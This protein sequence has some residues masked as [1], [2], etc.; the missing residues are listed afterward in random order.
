MRASNSRVLARAVPA[1]AILAAGFVYGFFTHKYQLPPYHL[2]RSLFVEPEPI[3][4]T[5]PHTGGRWE[6]TPAWI[7][8]LE[9]HA[10]GESG[11][12][13]A[14]LSALGYL[15][16]YI[17]PPQV[18]QVTTHDPSLAQDGLNL[19]VSGHAPEVH[20]INM[21]GEALHVW[22][23]EFLTI[24]PDY[25]HYREEA[26]PEDPPHYIFRAWP[27]PN[28][29]LLAL[30]EGHGL[31]KLD[32]DSEVLWSYAGATHDRPS[33][34]HHDLWVTD[35]GEVYVLTYDRGKNVPSVNDSSTIWEDHI[36]ILGPDGAERDRFSVIESFRSSPY[37]SLLE[38]IVRSPYHS[39][40]ANSIQVFDGSLAGASEVFRK[41][42]IL[43]SCREN[44]AVAIIDADSHQVVWALAG[45]WL[46]QHSARLLDDG[47]MLLFDNRG[48][49]PE[50]GESYFGSSKIMQFDPLQQSISWT[51]EGTD[52]RPFSCPKMGVCQRLPNGNTLV[53]DSISGRAFEVTKANEIVWEWV[54]PHRAGTDGEY[55]ATLC[56]MLRLDADFFP[57]DWR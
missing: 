57:L 14:R 26:S 42:N 20:L 9:L 3:A 47:S 28:G 48:R 16:G 31:V 12:T 39:L 56:Q 19:Y 40:H 17:P 53:T 24:W 52:Q 44:N 37:S 55:I 13:E 30:F 21:Q 1:L 22:R 5:P 49:D 43:I 23:R 35:E 18:D 29:D 25:E 51:Y 27:F 41:G 2:L 34:C 36:S 32:R 4:S 8:D 38:P 11:E 6:K 50:L 7:R 54:S 33:G 15:D 46:R 10:D 45:P